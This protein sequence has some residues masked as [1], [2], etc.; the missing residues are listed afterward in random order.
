MTVKTSLLCFLIMGCFSFHIENAGEQTREAL[1]AAGRGEAPEGDSGPPLLHCL[2]LPPRLPGRVAVR[3]LRP[4]CQDEGQADHG[5][6]RGARQDRAL[7]G[8]DQ[9]PQGR[10]RQRQRRPREGQQGL[11]SRRAC[12]AQ[13]FRGKIGEKKEACLVNA[14]FSL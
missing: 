7:G 1:R 11:T 8:A 13:P 12:D 9:G 3:R 10:P 14:V 5:R 6:A 2:R 4:L